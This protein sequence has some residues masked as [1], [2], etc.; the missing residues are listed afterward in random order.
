LQALFYM[1]CEGCYL[2]IANFLLLS[3][4]IITKNHAFLCNFNYLR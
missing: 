1:P 2:R 4:Q 3:I